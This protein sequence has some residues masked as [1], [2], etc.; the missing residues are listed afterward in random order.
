M[1][2][3]IFWTGLNG[4]QNPTNL[5]KNGGKRTR[6]QTQEELNQQLIFVRFCHQKWRIMMLKK[7]SLNSQETIFQQKNQERNQLE[8][9][10]KSIS[11]M[12][13]SSICIIVICKQHFDFVISS[14]Y[15][16]LVYLFILQCVQ[17][18]LGLEKRYNLFVNLQDLR[19]ELCNIEPKHE[20]E[21]A[22]L[23]NSYKSLYN[24]W[25]F[26]LRYLQLHIISFSTV[27]LLSFNSLI[28]SSF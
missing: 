27:I 7:M 8:S 11:L 23:I 18:Y 2:G 6:A 12:N 1:L 20:K 4:I 3:L 9:L 22:S 19:G 13:R 17:I 15:T 10:M 26:E 16:I 5:T 14:C 24:E 21:V 25:V 28:R